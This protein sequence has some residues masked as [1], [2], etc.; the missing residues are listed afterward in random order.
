M[1]E[2][3]H[4]KLDQRSINSSTCGTNVEKSSEMWTEINHSG[5]LIWIK[6]S[7]VVFDK[8]VSR[9]VKGRLCRLIISLAMWMELKHW[10]EVEKMKLM[11]QRSGWWDGWWEKIKDRMWNDAIREIVGVV[12]ASKKTQEKTNYYYMWWG[13]EESHIVRRTLNLQVESVEGPEDVR[14]CGAETASARIWQRKDLL[15]ET[16]RTGTIGSW[17]YEIAILELRRAEEKEEFKYT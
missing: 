7:G 10:Q 6:M 17:R 14:R 4:V 13:G 11:W 16:W 12:E 1:E 3:R 15:K 2:K 8:N 9:T 5:R